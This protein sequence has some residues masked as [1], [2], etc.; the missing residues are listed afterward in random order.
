MSSEVVAFFDEDSDSFCIGTR[1]AG[2]VTGDLFVVIQ[3][4][5]DEMM[6]MDV[7]EL[8]RKVGGSVLGLLQVAL[9]RKIC[10]RDYVGESESEELE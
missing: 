10:S 5:S 2:R 8:E 7:V 4:P 1:E 6:K 3:V 9:K